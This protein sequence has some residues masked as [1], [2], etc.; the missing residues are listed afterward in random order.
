VL[1]EVLSSFVISSANSGPLWGGVVGL[2][3]FLL[4][5][6]ICALDAD[7]LADGVSVAVGDAG[8]P[9][10]VGLDVADGDGAGEG[11]VGI[12]VGVG[13]V[14][15]CGRGR[16]WMWCLAVTGP[17]TAGTGRVAPYSPSGH[18]WLIWTTSPV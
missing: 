7:G 13:R 18:S 12:A 17:V 6:A 16:W 3:S 5:V 4:M 11:E 15:G 1:L 2:P 10:G 14:L 9:V 8:V